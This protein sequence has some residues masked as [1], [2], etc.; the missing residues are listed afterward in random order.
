[1]VTDV[2]LVLGT[3]DFAARHQELAFGVFDVRDPARNGGAVHV[4]VEN[5]QENAD[6]RAF[7]P[8]A[9][10]DDADHFA[11][12]WRDRYGPVRDGSLG[13]AEEV[14][15]EEREQEQGRGERRMNQIPEQSPGGREGDAV[16]DSV[17]DHRLPLL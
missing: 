13:V 12:G 5:V 8:G 3:G 17:L 9:V 4:N 14:E 6:A 7:G 10:P 1:M 15:A 11:V 16:I 2:S